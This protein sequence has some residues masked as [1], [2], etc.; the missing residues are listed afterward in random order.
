MKPIQYRKI[1]QEEVSLA[2]FAHFQRFQ[3]VKRCWRKAE[4]HWV[5]KDIAFTEDWEEP[6]YQRLCAQLKR[7][8]EKGG[9]LWGAFAGAR[10]KGFASVEGSLIGSGS[11]YAVLAE[12]HVSQDFRRHGLGQ[13]L[14]SLAAQSARELGAQKLYISA[15]S[16]EESQAFYQSMGCREAEEYDPRHVELEPCDCQMEYPLFPVSDNGMGKEIS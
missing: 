12:L 5:L 6:D 15:M 9:C 4:G 2:L 7:T 14:F 13:R 3:Q 10:L 8:L 16:A 1:G 11:Q